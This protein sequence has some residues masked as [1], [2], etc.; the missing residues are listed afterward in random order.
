MIQSPNP[1]NPYRHAGARDRA[2]QPGAARDA[3]RGLHRRSRRWRRRSRQPLRVERPIDATARTPRTSS[4]SCGQQLA[5]RYEAKDLATQNLVDL[6]VARPAPAGAR[7]A[8]AA[9]RARRASQKMIKKRTDAAGAGR[10][11]A[12]EPSTGA[13]WPSSAAAPTA[14]SQYN[15]VTQARRQPG[16]T[17]KPFVYLA[18]F[19][20]TFDDPRLPPITPATVVEDAPAVFFFEDKEYIPTEL[21][22]QLLG[23]RHAAHG[24][25]PQP[26]R[27]HRQGGGDGRLRPGGRPVV[28]EARDRRAR[29]SPIPRW[30]S[31]PSRPRLSRWPPPTTSSPTA[32][33]RCRRPRS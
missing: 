20:A 6:H 13:S 10:L 3:G 4:T 24:A 30:R 32:G 29:S 14:R 8:G 2:A 19:E 31:A 28:E 33:S 11:I 22:G 9:A 5:E 15:R 27:R 18:A 26:E 1:Y 12:L 21:R 16:S 23:L 7:A 25:R 17:F